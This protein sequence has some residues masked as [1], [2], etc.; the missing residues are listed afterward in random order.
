MVEQGGTQIDVR[1]RMFGDKLKEMQKE[2][3]LRGPHNSMRK[4]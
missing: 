1:L 3:I 2:M 4:R